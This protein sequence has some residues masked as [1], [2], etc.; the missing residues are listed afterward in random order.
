MVNI[1]DLL[2]ILGLKLLPKYEIQQLK[3]AGNTDP[4]KIFMTWDYLR[5]C[6]AGEPIKEPEHY[7][8]IVREKVLSVV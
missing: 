7:Q 6:P 3:K 8:A 5:D 1:R 2:P 4:T